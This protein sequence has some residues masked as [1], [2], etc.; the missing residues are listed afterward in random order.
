MVAT[1]NSIEKLKVVSVALVVA[2]EVNVVI[3]LSAGIVYQIFT[4]L[5]FPEL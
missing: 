2:A 4:Y 1:S 5:G 3:Y